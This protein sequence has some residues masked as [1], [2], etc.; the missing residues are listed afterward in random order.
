MSKKRPQILDIEEETDVD[1]EAEMMRQEELHLLEQE[2]RKTL[3]KSVGESNVLTYSPGFFEV[4]EKYKQLS[5]WSGTRQER[6]DKMQMLNRYLV[7][8][9][10]T[11]VILDLD[12]L[13]KEWPMSHL[14]KY[15]P[16][17]QEYIIIQQ[18]RISIYK[19]LLDWGKLLAPTRAI[20]Y[21]RLW[22]TNAF[23]LAFPDQYNILEVD[24]R[25]AL[26]KALPKPTITTD[27]NEA[28]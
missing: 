1:F 13:G 15:L 5:P 11:Q 21:H 6:K 3:I 28:E 20:L 12:F 17:R 2:Q 27:E 26:H 22:A 4:L 8:L 18:G 14:I 25:Y 16:N 9:T 10:G 7:E 23:R 19:F 24:R